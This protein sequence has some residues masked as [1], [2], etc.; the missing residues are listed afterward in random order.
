MG[1]RTICAVALEPGPGEPAAL[2]NLVGTGSWIQIARVADPVVL[3]HPPLSQT[4]AAGLIDSGR[5][6][7]YITSWAAAAPR[8]E[9]RSVTD[10]TVKLPQDADDSLPGVPEPVRFQPIVALTL[11]K[12]AKAQ[13]DPPLTSLDELLRHL[14]DPHNGPATRNDDDDENDWLCKLLGKCS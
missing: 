8:V 5:L 13:T 3:L 11:N 4:V 14:A 7:V 12:P 9:K 6:I 10:V 2:R 1:I